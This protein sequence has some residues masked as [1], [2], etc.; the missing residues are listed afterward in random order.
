MSSLGFFSSTWLCWWQKV[1]SK[2]SLELALLQLVCI[3]F[4]STIVQLWEESGTFS[5]APCQYVTCGWQWSLPFAFSSKWFSHLLLLYIKCLTIITPF[6]VIFPTRGTYAE[7]SLF[8]YCHKNTLREINA[9][10]CISNCPYCFSAKT[11]PLQSK[12]TRLQRGKGLLHLPSLVHSAA[13]SPSKLYP[14][15]QRY[16]T[17]LPTVLFS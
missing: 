12:H 6:Y 10:T 8:S 4:H 11:F 13:G 3:A 14:L 7:G 9:L 16:V 17:V 5:F 1:S 2:T 15:S